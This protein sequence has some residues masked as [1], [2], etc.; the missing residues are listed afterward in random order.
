[1]LSIRAL[2]EVLHEEHVAFVVVGGVAAIT[3]GMN[4]VTF[5]LDICYERSAENLSRLVQAL[6]GLAPQLR[7]ADDLPPLPFFWDVKTLQNGL[8]FTLVTDY[9][10]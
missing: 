1:M 4:Y 5:G 9:G 2:L 3:H 6:D 7:I 10:P 8:N